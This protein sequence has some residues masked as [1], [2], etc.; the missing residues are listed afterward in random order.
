MHV[1]LIEGEK[2]EQGNFIAFSYF[3]TKKK[4]KDI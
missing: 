2:N 1:S 3:S 4:R